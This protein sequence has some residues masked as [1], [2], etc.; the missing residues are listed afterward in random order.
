MRFISDYIIFIKSYLKGVKLKLILL[1]LNEFLKRA[2]LIIIPIITQIIIDGAIYKN[3]D[4]HDFYFYSG[5]LFLVTLFSVIFNTF[6]Y[7][8]K[9]KIKICITNEIRSDILSN[10]MNN[11]DKRTSLGSIYE[12]INND[13]D[14][15]SSFITNDIIKFIFNFIYV[16][17]V[18]ALMFKM[19]IILSILI[20]LLFPLTIVIN[21]V[22]SPILSECNKIKKKNA[23]DF[24]THVETIYS[25]RLTI[26][27]YNIF[28]FIHKMTTKVLN[29]YKKAI[30]KEVSIVAF[31]DFFLLTFILNLG[32]IFPTTVGIYF[33]YKNL[34]TIGEVTAFSLFC[35][36]LWNPIEFFMDFPALIIDR[37]NSFYRLKELFCESISNKENMVEISSQTLSF[38][39]LR[40]EKLGYTI[41]NTKVFNCINLE[42]NKGDKIAIIGKNGSGKTTLGKMLIKLIQPTSGEIFYND[43]P[44]EKIPSILLREKIVY[45]PPRAFIFPFSLKDNIYFDNQNNAIQINNSD[46]LSEIQK[47][48]ENELSLINCS[49]GE[50]K[51]I[52]V[53]RALNKNADLY[54]FD[55]PLA[56]LD[57]NNKKMIINLLIEYMKHKTVIFI[58]HEKEL[59]NQC[60]RTLEL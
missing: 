54:I 9:N 37:K 29:E 16:I 40:I 17:V 25:A 56:Y 10:V 14:Q 41:N 43:I 27:S 4:L 38:D 50:K 39:R 23:D 33:V 24:N 31:F 30:D 26:K 42:I 46:L 36:R 7:K 49:E 45:I 13:T 2:T 58:T 8:L 20:L 19:N 21:L 53:F 12:R 32:T 15:I 5:C 57:R 55:E 3:K 44:I 6:D 47:K 1:L 11:D 48:H 34:L 59:L 28:S 51:I 22:Y 35:S 18:V 52:E 60:D